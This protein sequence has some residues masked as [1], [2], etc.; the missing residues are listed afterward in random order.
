MKKTILFALALFAS[1]ELFATLPSAGS[2]SFGVSQMQ[3]GAPRSADS[4]PKPPQSSV[5]QSVGL[6]SAD[7]AKAGEVPVEH[8]AAPKTPSIL[9]VEAENYT[10]EQRK[11]IK[12][13]EQISQKAVKG[14]AD[15]QNKMG[16]FYADN[17]L[18]P[19][20]MRM[21]AYWWYEAASRKHPEALCRMGELYF[22]G[23]VMKKNTHRAVEYWKLSALAGN[24]QAQYFLGSCYANGGQGVYLDY[25]QAAFWWQKSAAQGNIRAMHNLAF[26]YARGQGVEKANS[27]M[28][29]DL[30]RRAAEQGFVPAQTQLGL[31]YFSG[32]GVDKDLKLAANIWTAATEKGDAEAQRLL[33]L[34]YYYGL[35]VDEDKNTAQVLFEAA[36]YQGDADAK[37]LFEKVVLEIGLRKA[38]S[39]A[40]KVVPLVP[41]RRDTKNSA[42]FRTVRKDEVQLN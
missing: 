26:C 4:A 37:K 5:S 24:A 21:A 19:R 18:I 27:R 11:K 42:L 6:K 34:C 12:E 8:I 2:A 25:E 41:G 33:G 16:D 29:Y 32:E 40:P 38:D 36:A 13:I 9:Q 30:W 31:C 3:G 14:D 39:P 1:L 15:A 17:D 35:G 20:D 23:T 28:A 22:S 10:Q 7:S